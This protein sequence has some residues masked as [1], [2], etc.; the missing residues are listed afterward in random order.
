M[1]INNPSAHSNR[2]REHRHYYYKKNEGIK[3]SP[4]EKALL[5]LVFNFSSHS[6]YPLN[7]LFS[8]DFRRRIIVHYNFGGET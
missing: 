2:C 4:I 8:V 7:S 3:I 5:C 6:T 1:F